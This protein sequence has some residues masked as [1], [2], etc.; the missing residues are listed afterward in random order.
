MF[1]RSTS[2]LASVYRPLDR[3]IHLMSF[4]SVTTSLPRV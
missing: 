3:A 1:P 2:P 4:V